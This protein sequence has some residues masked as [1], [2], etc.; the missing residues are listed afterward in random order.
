MYR[1]LVQTIAEPTSETDWQ[2]GDLAGEFVKFNNALAPLSW[3]K[4]LAVYRTTG[5]DNRNI[6]VEFNTNFGSINLAY[7]TFAVIGDGYMSY[8]RVGKV[9]NLGE[10]SISATYDTNKNTVTFT[11]GSFANAAL[12]LFVTDGLKGI[13]EKLD[14][15]DKAISE[16]A[17]KDDKEKSKKWDKVIDYLFYFI[18]AALLAY[19][20]NKIGIN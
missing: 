11:V 20:A 18:L 1:A 15:H 16:E 6:P 8:G 9:I 17:N 10:S 5:A 13:K 4:D 14:K 2:I 7:V 12:L 19:I 3:L